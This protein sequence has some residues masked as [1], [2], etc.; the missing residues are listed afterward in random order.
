MSRSAQNGGIFEIGKI[1]SVQLKSQNTTL[2]NRENRK[3]LG[4]SSLVRCNCSFRKDVIY[5]LY[6]STIQD[7]PYHIFV[8]V[9]FIYYFLLTISSAYHRD[10][11]DNIGYGRAVYP[12]Q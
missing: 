2:A 4:P 3:C 5:L 6:P 1:S 7:I 12:K 9:V 10:T 11:R 8:R